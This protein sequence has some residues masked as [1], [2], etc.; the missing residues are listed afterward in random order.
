MGS[1]LTLRDSQQFAENTQIIR[2]LRGGGRLLLE[3]PTFFYSCKSVSELELLGTSDKLEAAPPGLFLPLSSLVELASKLRMG[4]FARNFDLRTIPKFFD[5]EVEI[6]HGFGDPLRRNWFVSLRRLTNVTVDRKIET[7]LVTLRKEEYNDWILS[8]HRQ[9]AF[10]LLVEAC[11]QAQAKMDADLVIPFVP[12]IDGRSS[13]VTDL[14]VSI[15]RS[16]AS[17]IIHAPLKPFGSS[18]YFVLTGSALRNNGFRT[19][20]EDFLFTD[21]INEADG[22]HNP[23][24]LFIKILGLDE[25]TDDEM[26]EFRNLVETLNTARRLNRLAV[27]LLDSGEAGFA[28][29]A[30]GFDGYSEGAGSKLEAGGADKYSCEQRLDYLWM[31]R[32]LGVSGLLPFD[33]IVSLFERNGYAYPC[34]H[35]CCRYKQGVHPQHV[36]SQT[37]NNDAITHLVNTRLAL[38]NSYR[39]ALKTGNRTGIRDFLAHSVSCGRYLNWVDRPP[40]RSASE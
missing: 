27:F 36:G 35:K 12:V 10:W 38:I 15:N 11:V 3:L 7:D 39:E 17:T 32:D 14:A 34:Q 30:S 25:L 33:S 26:F 21:S 31:S 4:R 29:L 5:P 24:V 40:S 20:L 37:W 6:F 23:H 13:E 8:I 1:R 2:E 9:K 28:L 16:V 19:A 18:Y 22:E